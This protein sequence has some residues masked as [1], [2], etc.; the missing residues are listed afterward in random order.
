[1]AKL[2]LA[3]DYK[4]VGPDGKTGTPKDHGELSKG[5]IEYAV[6]AKYKDGLNGQLRRVY[7]RIQANIGTAIATEEY[8]IELDEKEVKF[9]KDAFS[10]E[11]TKFP[12]SVA[13]YV[14]ALEDAILAL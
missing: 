2:N 12:A 9:L 14:V 5:Y 8:E 7:G 4:L 13:Q 10:D 1:M 3:V 6:S 11:V